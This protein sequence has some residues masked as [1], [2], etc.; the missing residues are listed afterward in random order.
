[1]YKWKGDNFPRDIAWAAG[2]DAGNHSMRQGK[3]RKWSREDYN[4]AAR[5]FNRP[6]PRDKGKRFPVYK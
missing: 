2:L 5:T 6:C 3:R 4:V 1:M